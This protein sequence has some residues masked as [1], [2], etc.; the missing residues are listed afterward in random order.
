MLQHRAPGCLVF[1]LTGISF[2][3]LS[4]LNPIGISDRDGSHEDTST[5]LLL[6][7]DGKNSQEP[8]AEAK[9]KEDDELFGDVD[10]STTT[11]SHFSGSSE[12]QGQRHYSQ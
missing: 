11:G 4:S 10:R 3:Q 8:R 5:G 2:F 9:N 1:L 6:S 7:V 12:K